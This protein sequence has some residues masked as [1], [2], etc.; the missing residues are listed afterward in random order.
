MSLLSRM[1]GRRFFPHLRRIAILAAKTFNRNEAT[2]WRARLQV[3]NYRAPCRRI[4]LYTYYI[5]YSCAPVTPYI[6][7]I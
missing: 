7:R 6:F 2:A 3:P 1:A 4:Q 5:V